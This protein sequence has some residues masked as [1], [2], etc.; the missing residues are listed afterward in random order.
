[1]QIVLISGPQGSGKTTT[2]NLLATRWQERMEQTVYCVN[3]ADILYEMHNS[4]LSILEQYWP[5]RDLVKDGPLLQVLGT[6]WGRK[7]IDENI[8]V[9]CLQ[10]KL[11][12]RRA[13]DFSGG[14]VPEL[15]IVGDCRFE[16]EFDGF[17]EALRVRLECPEEDRKKR[18][19]MWR[20]NTK[21]PS[22]ISL[23]RYAA[24]GRFDLY[25]RTDNT[26]PEACVTLIMA[27]LQK[28]VWSEKRKAP[29]YLNAMR[30]LS[31][32][33][34]DVNESLRIIEEQ[35]GH[36]ANF[37]WIYNNA[38]Q[39]ELKVADVAPYVAPSKATVEAAVNEVPDIM[40]KAEEL[41]GKPME[42]RENES[43]R[44]TTS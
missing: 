15:V 16:N 8:W 35:T 1:M 30:H 7:T 44:P 27:Q 37:Q 17:P 31:N 28:N 20:D 10:N 3:F 32:L 33:T 39:K 26:D 34:T 21:H 6:D 2:Q 13:D 36:R 23:D 12:K 24:E 25:L 14:A 4:V 41:V 11:K 19:S 43:A 42:V 5:K 9:K 22:E 29:E 38:G 18:C 40:K